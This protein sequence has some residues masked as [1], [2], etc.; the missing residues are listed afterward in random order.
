[1]MSVA[2][3]APSPRRASS[4]GEGVPAASLH[5][6]RWEKENLPAVRAIFA[7]GSEEVTVKVSDEGGGIPRSELEQAW[8]YF[9]KLP[10][11]TD[12]GDGCDDIPSLPRGAGLPLTRLH[13]RYYGGD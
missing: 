12:R 9:D 11:N 8:S 3:S 4:Q 13:A 2:A 6:S 1:L 5:A 10:S 7:H